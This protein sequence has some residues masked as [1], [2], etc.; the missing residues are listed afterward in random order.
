[1][2]HYICVPCRTRL[3]TGAAQD[4]AGELCPNCGAMLKPVDDLRDAVGFAAITRPTARAP[5][6]PGSLAHNDFAGRLSEAITRRR[7]VAADGDDGLPMAQA[8][9]LPVPPGS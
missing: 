9:A 5:E 3:Y 2:P 1:M 8:V 7:A 4:Q 6:G